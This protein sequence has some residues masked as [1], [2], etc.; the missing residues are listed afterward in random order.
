MHQKTFQIIFS[1]S[2]FYNKPLLSKTFSGKEG[3]YHK[4]LKIKLWLTD[5]LIQLDD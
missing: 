3:L 2:R 5:Y 1:L 4:K